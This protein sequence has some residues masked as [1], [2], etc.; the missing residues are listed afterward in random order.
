MRLTVG[1]KG[2]RELF[3]EHSCSEQMLSHRLRACSIG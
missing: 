3:R 2:L 1:P